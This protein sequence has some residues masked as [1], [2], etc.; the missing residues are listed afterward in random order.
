[1]PKMQ[2]TCGAALLPNSPATHEAQNGKNAN[3][4]F[5]LQITEEVHVHLPKFLVGQSLKH[6][7]FNA[8]GSIFTPASSETFT[9]ESTPRFD[10]HGWSRIG[11]ECAE[12]TS[13]ELIHALQKHLHGFLSRQ[14]LRFPFEEDYSYSLKPEANTAHEETYLSSV[15]WKY[16]SKF[17]TVS[18]SKSHTRTKID[19]TNYVRVFGILSLTPIPSRYSGAFREVE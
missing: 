11:S 8:D 5:M 18:F 10:L 19:S 14:L 9:T 17:M 1:M 15:G 4:A 3:K 16:Y 12:F 6:P 7:L 2:K 13:I